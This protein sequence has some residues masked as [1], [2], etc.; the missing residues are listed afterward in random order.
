MF[1]TRGFTFTHETAPAWEERFAPLLTA[2]LKARRRG[3]AGRKWHVDET[4]V[5]VAGRRHYLYRAIDSDGN[6]VETMLSKTR[7]MD[8]AKRF[9]ACALKA[10][11]Q[12]PEK[13]PTDGHDSYP[14][15]VRETLGPA[16]CHRTSRSMN[17]RIEQDHPRHQTTLLPHA[18]VR[19]LQAQPPGSARPTTSYVIIFARVPTSTTLS[20]SLT[21]AACFRSAG[22][23]CARCSRLLTTPATAL[24]QPTAA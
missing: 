4:D 9:F 8:G 20:P 17:N 1:L 3:K 19:F 6:L 14:R 16:V 2:R 18:R 22:E 23:R 24:P 7:D 15:A 5:K 21:N 13:A 10:V 12:A 11:G